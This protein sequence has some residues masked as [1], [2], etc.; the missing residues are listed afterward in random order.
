MSDGAKAVVVML[1]VIVQTLALL[2]CAVRAPARGPA[3]SPHNARTRARC[4]YC[5][6][7]IP[8]GQAM[9]RKACCWWT[10]M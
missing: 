3:A 5:I 7:Y 6:T 10:K 1:L 8:F 4:R 2:W 9:L